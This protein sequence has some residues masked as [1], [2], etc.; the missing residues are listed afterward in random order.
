MAHGPSKTPDPPNLPNHAQHVVS[1]DE[2]D[3]ENAAPTHLPDRP[4]VNPPSSIFLTFLARIIGNPSNRLADGTVKIDLN[5]LGII[6]RMM[7]AEATRLSK[8]EERVEQLESFEARLALEGSR[9]A[10]L[11]SGMTAGTHLYAR[12]TGPAPKP[13]PPQI[14]PPSKEVLRSLKPAG[15][16]II[17]SNP[18]KSEIQTVKH[19][20]LVQRANEVLQKLDAKV[21]GKQISIR[22]TQ[23]LKLGDVCLFLKISHSRSGSWNTIIRKNGKEPP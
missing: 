13:T 19:G 15:K 2:M 1:E 14:Q 6:Q 7:E 10:P 21:K 16:A 17:H 5:S 22:G 4:T 3:L 18:D 8:L 11:T 12:G 20:F 23:V 9:Q